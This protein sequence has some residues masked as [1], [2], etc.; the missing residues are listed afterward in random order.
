ME[1]HADSS[2]SKECK[3]TYHGKDR[4]VLYKWTWA[5]QCAHDGT[6]LPGGQAKGDCPG[7][8][9]LVPYE[10]PGIEGQCRPQYAPFDCLDEA[11]QTA[12]PGA[13]NL[14]TG[15][16]KHGQNTVCDGCPVVTRADGKHSVIGVDE[17]QCHEECRKDAHCNAVNY[18]AELGNCVFRQ[19]GEPSDVALGHL[20]GWECQTFAGAMPSG[21]TTSIVLV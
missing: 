15:W 18:K 9:A 8:M 3:R 13:T 20:D 7:D 16:A 17:R 14:V 5:Y 6:T 11:C 2:F 12:G 19:C 1:S 4:G 10:C 21:N